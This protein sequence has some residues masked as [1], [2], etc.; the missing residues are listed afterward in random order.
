MNKDFNPRLQALILEIVDNQL[1]D[2]NPPATRTTLDRLMKS[3]YSEEDAR[4]MIGSVVV[5]FL[6]DAMKNG[7]QYDAVRYRKRLDE[8]K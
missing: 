8:L 3:G 4:K 2:N 6:F 5:E 1:S 7:I